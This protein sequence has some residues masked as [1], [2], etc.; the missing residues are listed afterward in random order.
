[1]DSEVVP[2]GAIGAITLPSPKPPLELVRPDEECIVREFQDGDVLSTYKTQREAERAV[3][4]QL[5][6]SRYPCALYW[7]TATSV[8]NIHWNELFERLRVEYSPYLRSWKITPADD[9]FMFCSVDEYKQACRLAK[10]VQREFEFKQLELCSKSGAVEK[11]IEHRYL[12][13]SLT[14]SGVQFT[15]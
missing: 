8:G 11:V 7:E 3:T 12:R 13:Q 6:N 1:M 14:E 10:T 5:S 2:T 9:H 15:G 4:A